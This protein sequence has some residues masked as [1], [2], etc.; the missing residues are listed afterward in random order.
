MNPTP[1]RK[2]LV[3]AALLVLVDAFVL[4]QGILAFVVVA[5]SLIVRLPMVAL[6]PRYAGSRGPRLR[7]I[8]LYVG[9]SI[10]VWACNAWNNSLAEKRGAEIVDAVKSFHGLHRRYPKSL[11]ELVPA[12]LERVP[13]AKYTLTFNRF[14]Y[15]AG[16]NPLL[17]YN[18]LPPFGRPV[19]SFARGEWSYLD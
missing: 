12:H 10:L 8:A 19:Y 7:N 17:M 18:D 4:N 11:E 15:I 14:Q 13:L 16:D 3:L 2:V 6:L 5:W 9:A 1:L